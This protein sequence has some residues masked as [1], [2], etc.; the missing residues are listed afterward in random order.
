MQVFH[1]APEVF[2]GMKAFRSV[3]DGRI[4]MFRPEMNMARMRKAAARAALPVNV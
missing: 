4:R 1:Y 2:E 3:A